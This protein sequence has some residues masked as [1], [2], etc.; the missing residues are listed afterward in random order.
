MLVLRAEQPQGRT[1]P[2]AAERQR[3]GP[4]TAGRGQEQKEK[5]NYSGRVVEKV[6]EGAG[7]TAVADG[8]SRCS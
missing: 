6:K 5:R 2:C 7:V 3:G 8:Y 4:R 1:A